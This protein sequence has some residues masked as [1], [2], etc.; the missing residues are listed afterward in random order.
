MKCIAT[1]LC[2]FIAGAAFLISGW[3]KCVDPAGFVY[4]IQD[5]LG[6][7][8]LTGLFPVDIILVGAIA[9]SIFEFVT[10]TALVTGSLPRLAPVAGVALMAFMLPLTIYIYVANPVA[11]CGCFGDLWVISNGATLLKNIVLT[12]LLIIAL[13]WHGHAGSL[14]MPTR[15]WLGLI[16]SAIYALVIA[17]VGWTI[18]PVVDFRPFAPGRDLTEVIGEEPEPAYIYERDGERRE[19]AL[20]ALPD[21][22]W[23]FVGPARRDDIDTAE[24]LAIFDGDDEVTDEVLTDEGDLLIMVVNNPGADYLTRA[25]MVRDLNRSMQRHGG[26]MFALVA[27][28]GDEL[29]QWESLAEPPFAV[30]SGGD[31]A[32]KQLA[33]GNTAIVAVRD[34]LV[35]WKRTL[36]TLESDNA[37]ADNPIDTIRPVDDG[38]VAGILT[39]AWLIAWVL[40]ICI[41]RLSLHKRNKP[42][43]AVVE[44]MADNP[45]SHI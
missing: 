4:K 6:A 39:V 10:G 38:R 37:F 1:W 7:W 11:N 33:R 3:A 2:R 20:S 15:Q 27:A 43:E 8:G 24:G 17:I 45:V 29:E 26:D 18:Q 19:F 25:R 12:A 32:L 28:S 30:Y 40:L 14:V 36:A 35:M 44:A 34:G 22:T 13:V 5:Y 16:I 21:S 9:L 31:V 41:N 23:T 42:D